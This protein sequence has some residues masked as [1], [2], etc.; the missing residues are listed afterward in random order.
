MVYS[1]L[2]SSS[3]WLHSVGICWRVLLSKANIMFSG[4]FLLCSVYNFVLMF[5]PGL[6]MIGQ[7]AI[8]N[9]STEGPWVLCTIV[10]FEFLYSSSQL[11]G[12]LQWSDP[13]L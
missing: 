5:K 2:A 9:G 10:A 6:R 7:D 1:E 11:K 3:E 12:V 8:S 4:V 13:A